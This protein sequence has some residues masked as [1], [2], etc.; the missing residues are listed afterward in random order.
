MIPFFFLFNMIL[1]YNIMLRNLLDKEKLLNTPFNVFQ[2]HFIL[3]KDEH[4]G[5]HLLARHTA[6][7]IYQ[8]FPSLGSWQNSWQIICFLP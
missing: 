6:F 2:V 5:E 3:A 4:A 1:Y 7:S 8:S